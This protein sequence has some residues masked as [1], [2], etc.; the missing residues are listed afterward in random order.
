MASACLLAGLPGCKPAGAAAPPPAKVEV[1][2]SRP[3]EREVVEWDEYTGHLDAPEYVNVQAQVSG[4]IVQA[5]FEEG[6]IVQKDALLYLIDERPFQ[7]DVAAKQASVDNAAAQV[8]VSQITLNRIKTAQP[9][10]AVSQQEYDTAVAT[11]KTAQATQEGAEAALRQSKINLG[12]CRV[13]APITGR[14]GRRNMTVG[15]LVTGGGGTGAPLT[16][17][18]SI[19]PMYL[20]VDVDEQSILRYQRLAAEKKRVSARDQHIPCFMQL[21]NEQNFPHVGVID[22]VNNQLDPNTGTLRARG[23]FPNPKGTLLAGMY[24][25]MRIAGSGRYQATLIPAAAVQTQQN[26]KI[27]LTVDDKNVVQPKTVQLGAAFGELQA[28]SEGI[29]PN[30]RVIISGQLR[31][32][33]GTTVEAT[34][35]PIDSNAFELT[36][37]GSPTTQ[38]LPATRPFAPGTT[39]DRE[40][41]VPQTMPSHA[42]APPPPVTQ[43]TTAPATQPGAGQ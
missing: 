7:A 40:T 12:W 9:G 27:V 31:A 17:I 39:G 32:R 26:L 10:A 4:Q 8:Q 3:L 15:N 1:T 14:V 28:V 38:D 24:A 2:V 18:V 36:A 19:D 42:A 23:V 13:T 43:P 29:G 25:T 34:E 6:A 37:A 16:T 21:Q 20:Y 22:F 30:D 11:L 5:P 33:P 35:K 41:I